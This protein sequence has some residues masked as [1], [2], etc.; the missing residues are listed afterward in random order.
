MQPARSDQLH[1]FHAP[2]VECIDKGKAAA[3]Y[4]F[5]VTASI[6]TKNRRAPHG[7]FVLRAE[8]LPDNLSDCHNLREVID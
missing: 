1:S 3:L 8:S 6:I 7:M 2:E 4:E 5:G